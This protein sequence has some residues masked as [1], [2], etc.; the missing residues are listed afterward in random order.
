MSNK[1]T[2]K[3]IS[4]NEDTEFGITEATVTV[5][6]GDFGSRTI[7]F[8]TGQLARQAGGSVT[9]YLDEDT[10]LL[11]TV[12][13]SKQP[14]EGFDFFPLTVDV[15]ERMYAA[16]ADPR[17]ILSAGRTTV[18]RSHSRLPTYRPSIASNLCQRAAER[19]ASCGDG[20]IHRS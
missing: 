2:R 10:M 18:N 16:G 1:N 3:A 11:S 8:E 4:Y 14:R 12:T 9:T 20:F 15:E 7:R 5:D 19:S 13:A 6:N 17:I